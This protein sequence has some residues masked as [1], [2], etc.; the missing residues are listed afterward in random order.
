LVIQEIL[1]NIKPQPVFL[2]GMQGG[3]F[4]TDNGPELTIEVVA[5]KGQMNRA[6]PLTLMEFDVVKAEASP[7]FRWKK[8]FNCRQPLPLPPNPGVSLEANAIMPPS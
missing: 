7:R 5:A 1:F 3:G 4:I 6:K 2:E 8:S